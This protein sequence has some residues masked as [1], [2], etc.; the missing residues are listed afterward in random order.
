MQCI[1]PQQAPIARKCSRIEL[2]LRCIS[3]LWSVIHEQSQYAWQCKA[4]FRTAS[5]VEGKP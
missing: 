3:P 4:V 1:E 2:L 5:Q